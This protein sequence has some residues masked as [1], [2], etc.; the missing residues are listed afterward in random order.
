MSYN[1]PKQYAD[2]NSGLKIYAGANGTSSAPTYT[3]EGD[4]D[5]G[6]YK[7]ATT[8]LNFTAGGNYGLNL[9]TAVM[10]VSSNMGIGW[11]NAQNLG[12]GTYDT[13]LYRESAGVIGQYNS[14]FNDPQAFNIYNTYT[15][16]SNYERLE[17]KWD[18]NV[19][20]ISATSA[21]TGS[22][23]SLKLRLNELSDNE[24]RDRIIFT[25]NLDQIVVRVG[26]NNATI[27]NQTAVSQLFDFLPSPTQG[28]KLGKSGYEWAEI[29][30]VDGNFSGTINVAGPVT[31]T[32]STRTVS[33]EAVG[34]SGYPRA[35]FLIGDTSITNVALWVANS[36][37]SQKDATLEALT[38]SDTSLTATKRIGLKATSTSGQ[39]YVARQ[40]GSSSDIPLRFYPNGLSG[41]FTIQTEGTEVSLGQ[42]S[43]PVD[44]YSYN[45]YTNA[46]NYER[47]EVKWDTNVATIDSTA[48][49][50]GTA[51]AFDISYNGSKRF[52]G[53]SAFSY[54]YQANGTYLAFGSNDFKPQQDSTIELG[55]TFSRW[56]NTYT[57]TITIG[58]GVDAVLTADAA[59][60]L[61]LRN[62]TTAQQ[63]NVYNTYTD[64][65]NY[66]R[67]TI[68]WNVNDFMI[69]ANA[70]G[71]GFVQDLFLSGKTVALKYD[72]G[73]VPPNTRL[74]VDSASVKSYRDFTPHIDSTWNCGTSSL[75]WNFVVADSVLIGDGVD[76][77][78]T[79]DA[80]NELA[81]RSGTDAQQ[82]N[83]YNTYTD[84]SNYERL[85]I[86]WDTDIATIECV[87]AGSGSTRS[88][89]IKSAGEMKLLTSAGEALRLG[90][91][92]RVNKHFYPITDSAFECGRTAQRWSNT[93][94]DKITIG[95][96]T[97]AIL[98]GDGAGKIY[99]GNDS[100]QLTQFAVRGEDDGAGNYNQ[101]EMRMATNGAC[102]LYSTGYGTQTPSGVSI[103][104]NGTKTFEFTATQVYVHQP[105][106]PTSA[107]SESLGTSS[108]PFGDLYISSSSKIYF[109]NSQL[110]GSTGGSGIVLE[111]RNGTTEQRYYLYNTY[112]DASNY[113]RLEVKWDTNVA[114]IY[115]AAAGTGSLRAI[116]VG[117]GT[118]RIAQFSFSGV[119]F[120]RKIF[121]TSD[122]SLSNGTDALRW[123]N[124]FT[125]ALTVGDGVDAVT[126]D[127]TGIDAG[128]CRLS[129]NS[130]GTVLHLE[131]NSPNVG[132][133]L[134]V[135]NAS[136]TETIDINYQGSMRFHNTTGWAFTT[137]QAPRIGPDS[138]ISW[139]YG[140]G[141]AM[142]INRVLF[143]ESGFSFA[144]PAGGINSPVYRMIKFNSPAEFR[145][146]K[147]TSGNS[148][149]IIYQIYDADSALVNMA[150]AGLQKI[151]QKTTGESG[152]FYIWNQQ[153][154]DTSNYERLEV[155][156]DANE[157]IIRPT[158]AG[159]GTYRG[160]RMNSAIVNRSNVGISAVGHFEVRYGSIITLEQQNAD[161]VMVR[162]PFGPNI[163]VSG[164][165][166]GEDARRWE[167]TFTQGI[168]TDVETFTATDTLD[169]KNQVCL[170]N[171]TTGN[172]TLN[173][174]VAS[175]TPVGTQY[176]IKKIDSS[177]NTVIITPNSGG[178]DLIDG[179]TTYTLSNQWEGVIIVCDG[180][181][182]YVTGGVTNSGGGGGGGLGGGD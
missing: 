18:A 12:Q 131:N 165:T 59:N 77:I 14:L 9:G 126:I 44:F 147:V 90:S 60:T 135:L 53:D 101:L 113:E 121:P 102:G 146:Q 158:Y 46:S 35:A 29:W 23:R 155:K 153:D 51:R 176:Q 33:F 76:I 118:T 161:R 127:S 55:A 62:S 43:S 97:D 27:Y 141:N 20:T 170:C 93:F 7:A 105:F 24:V 40:F 114:S 39:I 173:L 156:W 172:I 168:A 171:A 91:V 100:S 54:M 5:M 154:Y 50:T 69:S 28:P 36:T 110:L 71:S 82:L 30:S 134:R 65:S 47:L 95:D 177:S 49:G 15:D 111:Q 162:V 94:T 150:M 167:T 148:S 137:E 16:A 119:N 108:V 74:A 109:N 103:Y 56:L 61:A 19:A 89:N 128:Q 70:D 75:R 112:T 10:V 92:V 144:N 133:L 169:D 140:T 42:D 11:R 174:P 34:S 64:A 164:V 107:G 98:N 37:T 52:R 87:S 117:L 123:S 45:T 1:I 138:G 157:A 178:G 78:L 125:D 179:S 31:S 122:S 68:G 96:G 26:G 106:R 2:I 81:L 180:G 6:M 142:K 149:D 32:D 86:K 99:M 139:Y 17:V 116:G 124:T 132:D 145:M 130:N 175:S 104:H 25:S 88:L 8:Q 84:A 63:F 72:S 129:S 22:D 181:D 80:D 73:S 41:D 38:N 66:E 57:D 3:F 79:A 160:V 163:A 67:G 4:T 120:D 166:L 143:M 159:T 152:G 83:V 85:E 58:D 115:T 151:K 48:A 21:G 13:L 136:G 182:W